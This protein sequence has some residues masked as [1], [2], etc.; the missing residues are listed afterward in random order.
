MDTRELQ[1]ALR[2]RLGPYVEYKGVYTSDQLPVYLNNSCPIAFISNTLES[3]ADISTVGHWVAFYIEFAPIKKVLFFDSYGLLPDV[4]SSYY[5]DFIH[6]SYSSFSIQDFGVQLQPNS[7]HKCGM[8]VLHFI[9]FL[10]HHGVDKYISFFHSQFN[11]KNLTLNDSIVTRYYFNYLNRS[12]SCVYWKHGSK[13]AIT[14]AECKKY[15][16]NNNNNKNNSIR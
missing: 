15:N 4:Y 11:P 2:G 16:R 7:S 13:R 3:K 14:Y 9:H 1:S 5:S 10:S 8:Y 6:K 12:K